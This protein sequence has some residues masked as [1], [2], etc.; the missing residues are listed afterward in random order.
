MIHVNSHLGMGGVE[1]LR[2][3]GL[4]ASVVG[5]GA[6]AAAEFM[7]YKYPDMWASIERIANTQIVK[8]HACTL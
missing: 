7:K 4:L 5:A 6:K 3:L 8:Q 1:H 2:Q